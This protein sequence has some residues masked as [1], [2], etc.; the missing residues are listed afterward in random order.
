MAPHWCVEQ[1]LALPTALGFRVQGGEA[2]PYPSNAAQYSVLITHYERA[3]KSEK[4]R[5]IQRMRGGTSELLITHDSL[6][7]THYPLLMTHDS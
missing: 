4:A 3:R 6:L 2:T 7:I 1:L 5:A